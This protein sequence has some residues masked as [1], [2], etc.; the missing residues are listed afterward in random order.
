MFM[1]VVIEVYLFVPVLV[2]YDVD[3]RATPVFMAR[4]LPISTTPVKVNTQA[5]GEALLL[6]FSLVF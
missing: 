2:D 4:L 6:P 3:V 5:F 1:I